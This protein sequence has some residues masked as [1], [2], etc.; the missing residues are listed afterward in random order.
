MRENSF[1]DEEEAYGRLRDIIEKQKHRLVSA[2][3]GDGLQTIIGLMRKH[4]ISQLPVLDR[5][6][7]VGMISEVDLLNALLKDPASVDRPV[8][9]LVDQNYE[10]VPP[11]TPASRLAK[12]FSEGKVALV[13]EDNAITAVVTKID[14]IAHMAGVMK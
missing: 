9:E 4:G 1:L 3:P 11:D 10:I 12:I 6:R 14:L 8:A 5:D 13:Q 7:L 2:A